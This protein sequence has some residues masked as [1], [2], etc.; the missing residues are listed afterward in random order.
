MIKYS[1]NK[2]RPTLLISNGTR[3]NKEYAVQTI[4]DYIDVVSD[5]PYEEPVTIRGKKIN[6][7]GMFFNKYVN[8]LKW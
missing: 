5:R 2:N 7:K 3:I 1:S 6:S 8:N 4:H